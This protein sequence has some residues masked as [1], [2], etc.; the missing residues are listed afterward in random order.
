MYTLLQ[1]HDKSAA[2]TMTL[3]AQHFK[4]F[5]VMKRTRI[6]KKLYAKTWNKEMKD[7]MLDSTYIQGP[8][9]IQYFS[10]S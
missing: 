10:A 8:T 1:S 7:R 9:G 5:G 3:I 4:G 2:T 6:I